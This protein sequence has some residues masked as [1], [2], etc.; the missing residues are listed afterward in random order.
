ML[1][2]RYDYVIIDTPPLLPVTDGAV[3]ATLTDGAILIARH[4]KSS[5]DD[6]EQAAD[7]LEAVNA[8]LLGTVLNCIPLR[9]KGYSYGYGYGYG[10]ADEPA[11]QKAKKARAGGSRRPPARPSTD[12]GGR[13]RPASRHRET[14]PEA[15]KLDL[16]T[17]LESSRPTDPPDPPEL[18]PPSTPPSRVIHAIRSDHARLFC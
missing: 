14:S 10:Y 2:A 11:R 1:N 16:R 3:L 5:R 12:D 13:R 4:G 15:F 17:Y 18:P 7:A 9:A 6:L 8:K